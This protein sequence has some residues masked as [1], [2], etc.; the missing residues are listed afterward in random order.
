MQKEEQY[1]PAKYDSPG[2]QFWSDQTGI[3]QGLIKGH[4]EPATGKAGAGE[5]DVIPHWHWRLRCCRG[6]Q[7]QNGGHGRPNPLGA[8]KPVQCSLSQ[9][10]CART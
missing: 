3:L 6:I 2:N 10:A 4:F 9:K 5:S 8:K 7:M 1:Q